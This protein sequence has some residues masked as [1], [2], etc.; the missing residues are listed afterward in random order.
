VAS[1]WG[2]SNDGESRGAGEW[3]ARLGHDLRAVSVCALAMGPV[4]ACTGVPAGG[5][6]GRGR[7]GGSAPLAAGAA[8]G[9]VATPSGVR[10]DSNS[11]AAA[12][13]AGEWLQQGKNT[14]KLASAT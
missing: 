10:G 2:A 4:S 7:V 14:R 6:C 12:N 1:T 3:A 8:P 9:D 11:R 13:A 5:H